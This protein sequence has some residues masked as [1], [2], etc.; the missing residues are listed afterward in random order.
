[1]SLQSL[2]TPEALD[3]HYSG[4]NRT[5]YISPIT[6]KR[7][8]EILDTFEPYRKSN[9]IL[10]WGCGAGDFLV[11]A[12]K[13]GWKVYGTEYTDE[14]VKACTEKGIN[15]Q[16]GTLNIK[17]YSQGF[18]DIITSFEVL[19]HINNPLEEVAHFQYL[20]RVGG[21]HYLTT[22][23]F[24]ALARYQLK[25]KYNV[26]GYPEHL[27][28][29]TAQTL[30]KLFHENGFRSIKIESTGIS[31]TRIKTSLGTSKQLLISEVS[32]DEKLRVQIEKHPLL[33]VAKTVANRMFSVLGIG[34]TLKG[35]FEK[36]S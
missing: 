5:P 3:K 4:Y 26:I 15:I 28:Y 16:K 19:E 10:D 29:Y 23:N 12:K 8:H 11:E 13:R 7:Y 2:P 14:A 30:K 6:I 1:L 20:L 22:P 27:S 17:N 33:Q 21:L 18:F 36:Q 9:T 34:A 35:Y 24:N 25:D 32:D 31:L